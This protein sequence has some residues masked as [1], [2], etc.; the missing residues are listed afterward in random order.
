MNGSFEEV[1]QS[2][3][4]VLLEFYTEWCVPCKKMAP[5]LREVAETFGEDLTII[6]IDAEKNTALK[7]HLK[8]EDVPTLLLYQRGKL[9]WRQSGGVYADKLERIIREK[10]K[11]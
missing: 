9:L 10:V 1:I 3:E 7:K 8:V 2:E 11:F 4:P 6:K 5:Q